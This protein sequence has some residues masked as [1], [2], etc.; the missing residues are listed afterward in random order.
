M[1]D[2]RADQ[3]DRAAAD[4]QPV[5]RQDAHHRLEEVAVAQ[6]AV[7]G[8]L[9]PHQR[10]GDAGDV[11]R[12]RVEQHAERQ[13]PEVGVGEPHR[14]ELRAVDAR[15]DVVQHR[16][17]QAAVPAERADVDV[18]DDVVGVVRD[19]VDVLERHHRPLERRHAVGGH[20]HHHELQHR[21]LAHP[22]PGA[23]QR[24]QPVDHAAPGRRDQHEGEHRAE[25]LRPVGQRRVQQVVRPGPDVDEDQR[26]EVDDRQP[27]REH[28]P[29]GG[30]RD[31]VVH[32][33]E[34]RRGQEERHGVVAVPPLHQRVLHARIQ[35]VALEE[36]DRQLERVDDVQ[37][38]DG[39]ERGEVEPDRHVHVP[40]APLVDGAEHVQAEHH[41]DQRDG[42]VDRPLEF[43]VL[44][45][46]GE[47]ERQRQRRR[48][49]DQLPAPEV[50]RAERVAEHARLA[51]PLQRVVHAD[52]DG[53]AGKGED[54]RVGVQRPQPAVRQ[55]RDEVEELR[56]HQLDRD[57]QADEEPDDAPDRRS[58][59]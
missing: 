15:H 34:E 7:G 43:G 22:V 58:R 42:D 36:A 17:R 10:L 14:V 33:P 49:D 51:Q 30:L 6:R 3:E 8:E 26:P 18:G 2:Q 21:V 31:E 23:A 50:D 47:A 45:A 13:Q 48:D 25:R 4:P 55:L 16:E 59:R 28:R 12:N 32:D 20:A 24:Q 40:L 57:D 35:R 44:L 27:V 37:Q 41:P 46:G 54:H 19:R 38:R 11:E 9:L 5:H 52:E 53:V 56:A 29:A 39:D 1:A